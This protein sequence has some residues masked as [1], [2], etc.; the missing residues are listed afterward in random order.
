MV[1]VHPALRLSNLQNLPLRIK[2]D[3]QAACRVEVPSPQAFNVIRA[4][5]SGAVSLAAGDSRRLALLPFFFHVLNPA[6]IPVLALPDSEASDEPLDATIKQLLRFVIPALS[7]L[8]RIVDIPA[9][10]G[11]TLWPRVWP[12]FHFF[13]LHWDQLQL[14]SRL[15]SKKPA[16]FRMFLC[17]V[18]SFRHGHNQH[19]MDFIGE[20]PGFRTVLASIWKEHVP[21]EPDAGLYGTWLIDISNLLLPLAP[22]TKENADEF[23]AGAGGNMEDLAA[24][25]VW[26]L[27]TILTNKSLNVSDEALVYQIRVMV[28]F[29]NHVDFSTLTGDGIGKLYDEDWYRLPLGDLFHCLLVRADFL[30]TLIDAMTALSKT[31]VADTGEVL[32]DLFMVIERIILFKQG[33]IHPMQIMRA[34][35]LRVIVRCA[36]AQLPGTSRDW[37]ADDLR[38]LLVQ[39]L[40]LSCLYRYSAVELDTALA[41]PVVQELA[42]HSAFVSS[43]IYVHWIACTKM[44]QDRQRII[45]RSSPSVHS[46][47]YKICDNSECHKMLQTSKLKRCSHCQALSYCSKT[48][49]K[50][51]WRRGGHRGACNAY[52]FLSLT[53]RTDRYLSYRDRKYLRFLI[54]DEYSKNFD[55]ICAK[56]IVFLAAAYTGIQ[57]E[58]EYK[59]QN[60]LPVTLFNHTSGPSTREVHST[61]YIAQLISGCQPNPEAQ[62]EWVDIVARARRSDGR[63][64]LRV[65]Y[66]MHLNSERV[67]V[68]PLFSASGALIKQ[69]EGLARVVAAEWTNAGANEPGEVDFEWTEKALLQDARFRTLRA[70]KDRRDREILN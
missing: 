9:T 35:I 26:H 53:Y 22:A 62:H 7:T 41:D 54:E 11:P 15:Y 45:E 25:I 52:A 34:G 67:L 32:A 31:A 55:E 65:V 70:L 5:T 37:F 8:F 49:Q 40:Q 38:R 64:S 46:A 33:D 36:S 69:M 56:Q 12:W 23:I 2:L 60:P 30:P 28:A 58:P 48:C 20:T 63:M 13:H 68:L 18:A 4:V 6:S 42:K 27:N 51:D 39:R 16:L 10:A 1:P 14:D 17:F 3:A 61:D 43:N 59:E 57:F 44:V 50:T 24:L 29:L 47:E 66:G 21:G 19:P